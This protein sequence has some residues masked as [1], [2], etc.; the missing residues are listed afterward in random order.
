M[1]IK[2]DF[3]KK[4]RGAWSKHEL[5]GQRPIQ[6]VETH[7]AWMLVPPPDHPNVD[8][9]VLPP[10]SKD[11]PETEEGFRGYICEVYNQVSDTSIQ[12][13]HQAICN[14]KLLLDTLKGRHARLTGCT[15]ETDGA[16]T[17]NSKAVTIFMEEMGRVTGIRVCSHTHNEPGHGSDQCDSCGANCVR[18]VLAWHLLHGIPIDHALQTVGVLQSSPGLKGMITMVIEHNPRQKLS[19]HMV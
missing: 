6:S 15:R 1:A 13:A 14:F 8:W 9:N 16:T 3:W 2:S 4:Y 10:G 7:C 17:Y 5:C 12:D 18:A 19:P 11:L